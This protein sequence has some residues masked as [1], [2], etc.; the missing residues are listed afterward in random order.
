MA[1]GGKGAN[2]RRDRRFRVCWRGAFL[3]GTGVT[4]LR[5][6]GEGGEGTARLT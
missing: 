5:G 1:G 2:L 6:G 3:A 4:F